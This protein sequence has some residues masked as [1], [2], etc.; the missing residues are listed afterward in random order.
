MRVVLSLAIVLASLAP[1]RAHAQSLQGPVYAVDYDQLYSVDLG[2]RTATLI[3]A[4]GSNGPQT[5]ADLS[6]LTSAP[7]GTLYAASDTIKG[8]VRINAATGDATVIGNFGITSAQT[9]MASDAPLDFGMTFGCDG[10]LWLSSAT[11]D[12]L[13]TVNPAT[14]TSTLV[15]ALGHAISGLT[16]LDGELYGTGTGD[17]PGLYHIDTASGAA[18]LVGSF[19]STVPFAASTSPGVDALG[20]LLAAINY[21]PPPPGV[22]TTSDWSDLASIDPATGAATILGPITGPDSLRGIGI[23]GISF[24]PADCTAAVNPPPGGEPTSGPTTVPAGGTLSRLLELL[25]LLA[26]AGL[27]LVRGRGR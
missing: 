15:G 19:G 14:G 6:G 26:L 5:I 1:L 24:G 23:R 21:V 27:A 8:L 13:W 16:M 18:S 2:T 22:D 12:M 7:D 17:D 20:R 11:A 9:G 4:A 10:Q 25:G 3:G